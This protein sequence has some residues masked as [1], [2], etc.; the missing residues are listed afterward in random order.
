MG[1][2]H[3]CL[4]G[5]EGFGASVTWPKKLPPTAQRYPLFA[6]A[7]GLCIAYLAPSAGPIGKAA[8]FA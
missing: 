7:P 3:A 1:G 5:D 2:E 6:M 8:V 4:P